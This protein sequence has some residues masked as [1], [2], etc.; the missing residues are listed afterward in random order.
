V[1]SSDVNLARL[2]LCLRAQMEDVSVRGMLR[3]E[4]NVMTCALSVIDILQNNNSDK[5]LFR[6]IVT[7][8]ERMEQFVG[9]SRR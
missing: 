1:A 5:L 2:T 8:S 9:S 7:R 4:Q 3:T 6:P